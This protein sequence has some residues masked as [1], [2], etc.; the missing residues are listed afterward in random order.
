[1]SVRSRDIIITA[2]RI[3][4][5]VVTMIPFVALFT[6]WATLDGSVETR[7]GVGCIALLVSPVE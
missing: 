2:V 6:P 3:V 7:S 1:M 4:S 5:F